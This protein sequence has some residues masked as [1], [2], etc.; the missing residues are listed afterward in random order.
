MKTFTQFLTES[1]DRMRQ[2][3]DS[4]L[5]T[6]VKQ[7]TL[8]LMKSPTGKPMLYKM[9]KIRNGISSFYTHVLEYGKPFKN[10]G[11]K[12]WYLDQYEITSKNTLKH[13]GNVV[14]STEIAKKLLKDLNINSSKIPDTSDDL[15]PVTTDLK[16]EST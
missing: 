4:K 16:W 14:V 3:V 13:V 1:G 10:M 12:G 8:Y 7:S 9:G 5:P 6:S 15:N 11:A 2:Y